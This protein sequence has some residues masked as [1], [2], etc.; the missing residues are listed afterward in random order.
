[1]NWLKYMFLL[2]LC[3]ASGFAQNLNERTIHLK[4]GELITGQIVSVDSL[5]GDIEM[6]THYGSITIKG[7]DI[8]KEIITIILNSGD[9]LRGEI[10]YEDGQK[11][12]L[13]TQY[14]ML[15]IEKR[16]IGSIDFG[17]RMDNESVSS[18]NEKYTM[19]SEQ[20]V[21]VF[22]DPTGYTLGK[23]TLYVSG[24]S[25]GFGITDKFQ[26]TSKWSGYFTGDFNVRPKFQILRIGNLEKQHLVA[27]GGHFHTRYAPDKYEWQQSKYPFEV[28]QYDWSRTESWVSQG[29]S[30]DLYHGQFVR[31]GSDVKIGE[32]N[33]RYDSQS[34]F[35][36]DGWLEET[37]WHYANYYE[38]FAVYTYTKAREGNSGRIS[39]SFGAYLSKFE[40]YNKLMYRLYYAGAV[41]I[42]KNL[43]FNY[44]LFY[45]PWY[46]EWW[47]RSDFIFNGE[48]LELSVAK[49]DKE[50]TS[51]LHFDIG[52]IYS[53]S[54]WLRVG[55]HFQ[56]YIAGIYLK[57]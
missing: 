30:I 51:P 24:L 41:D 34:K 18:L 39:H 9:K 42:K 26:L 52:F 12:H 31:I 15:F 55:L 4:S 8:L 32:G 16:D 29:D 43:I 37:G 27:V 1:M 2:L 28:G 53:F 36:T 25:W 45:D 23:G 54:D 56:P 21:D 46:I 38:V 22:Y 10:V 7:E 44:E 5:R 3:F 11:I 6:L 50:Y 49:P 48:D 35:V 20:Q 40:D 14:G 17:L 33:R 47:K 57:F 19:G 13:Q